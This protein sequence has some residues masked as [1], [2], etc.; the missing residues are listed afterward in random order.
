M[1]IAPRSDA[2]FLL[3]Q[4]QHA[5]LYTVDE[6]ASR[7]VFN[8]AASLGFNA[9]RINLRLATDAKKLMHIFERALHFPDWFGA[10]WDALAD[11]LCDMSW[12]EADGYVLVLQRLENLEQK[13]PETITMLFD[14]LRE[15]T[16]SWCE[17][18]IPFWILAEGYAGALPRL[19]IPT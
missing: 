19:R 13:E 9:Y 3:K 17:Q 5:G 10:N 7:I 11:C 4:V 12:Q 16:K 2:G 15:T 6:D 1:N 14:I 18:N 8:A